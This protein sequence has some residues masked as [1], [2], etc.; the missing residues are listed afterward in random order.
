MPA[1]LTATISEPKPSTVA[2]VPTVIPLARPGF[3]LKLE[4][5]TLF[6]AA[7][8]AYYTLAGNWWMFAAL[9]LVPDLFMIGYFL[10]PVW[11][12]AGYNLGHTY[13]LPALLLGAGWLMRWQ[14]AVLIAI[15]WFAHI[16]MDRTVGYGLK[17]STNFKDT[18]L[19]HV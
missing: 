12:A 14:L 13:L 4:G 8:V 18:H 10:N 11:G 19:Q 16:G 9:L 1:L 5:L 15:I 17:Y 6:I 2:P 7:L 3:L